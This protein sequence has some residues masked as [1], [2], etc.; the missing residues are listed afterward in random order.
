MSH[1]EPVI[2]INEIVIKNFSLSVEDDRIPF[3]QTHLLLQVL[4]KTLQELISS[5]VLRS[6]NVQLP[7]S[8]QSFGHLVMIIVIIIVLLIT[9]K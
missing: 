5:P 1:A 3:A 8:L 9:T 2:P 4:L 7:L 6:I